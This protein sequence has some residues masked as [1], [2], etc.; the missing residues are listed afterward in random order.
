MASFVPVSRSVRRASTK[1]EDPIEFIKRLPMK[2]LWKEDLNLPLMLNRCGHFHTLFLANK[3]DEISGFRK[4]QVRR[5]VYTRDEIFIC[6][7][8]ED[9]IRDMIPL[10]EVVSVEAEGAKEV[11]ELSPHKLSFG[12]RHNEPASIKQRLVKDDSNLFETSNSMVVSTQL[13]GYNSGR[14]Y[15]FQSDSQNACG[16]LVAQLRKLAAE[17]RKREAGKTRFR[18]SQERLGRVINSIPFQAMLTVIILAVSSFSLTE[19]S[20]DHMKL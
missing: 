16:R 20:H 14:Q 8:D 13:D 3:T 12:K 7:Q 10:A 1:L 2:T 5:V 19:L 17:A 15:R 9:V 6:F 11:A 18:N 4:W